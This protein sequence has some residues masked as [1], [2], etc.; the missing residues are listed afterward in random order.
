MLKGIESTSKWTCDKVQCIINLMEE[1][2]VHVKEKL[3]KIYSRE[4]VDLLFS[5]PYCR[6]GNL[7][8][9][10]IVK[11]QTASEYL[12]KLVDANV[13]KVQEVGRE[14]IFVNPRFMEILLNDKNS[15]T[16]F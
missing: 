1:T 10:G 8:D 16:P 14:K 3:P 2:R 7:V 5:Q 12:K 11:R 9:E 13:L 4:L 15:Y 6:I